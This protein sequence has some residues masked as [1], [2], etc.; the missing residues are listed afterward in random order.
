MSFHGS[1]PLSF[2]RVP[3]FSLI[4]G[5]MQSQSGCLCASRQEMVIA[6]EP[7]GRQ[8]LCRGAVSQGWVRSSSPLCCHLPSSTDLPTLSL[9]FAHRQP[10]SPGWPKPGFGQKWSRL[11]RVKDR[12]LDGWRRL[13]GIN[14]GAEEGLFLVA[15][16]PLSHD[17]WLWPLTGEGKKKEEKGKKK[18]S[19]Q[20]NFESPFTCLCFHPAAQIPDSSRPSE[21]TTHWEFEWKS[22]NPR[23]PNCPVSLVGEGVRGG[24]KS[25]LLGGELSSGLSWI[26]H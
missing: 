11:R 5:A 10:G 18:K 25:N 15:Y 22:R 17:L 16:S 13:L 6:G 14:E 23:P 7:R 4:L 20:N 8:S 26:K 2:S 3:L 19:F 1:P 21:A 12:S 9:C 24:I